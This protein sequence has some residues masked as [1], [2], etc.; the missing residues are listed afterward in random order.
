M[1]IKTTL[2]NIRGEINKHNHLYYVLGRPVVS[3]AEYDELYNSL[4][5]LEKAYPDLVTPTSPTQRVGSDLSGELPT[6]K[7]SIPILSLG[8]AYSPEEIMDFINKPEF[9]GQTF[10]VGP[11]F[12]GLSFSA[13]YEDGLFSRALSRGDGNIGSIITHAVRTI[14]SL[15]LEIPYKKRLEVRG[16][17]YIPKVTFERINSEGKYLSARNLAAGTVKLLDCTEIS[18]RGLEAV[19]YSGFLDE[20]FNKESCLLEFLRGLGFKVI[21]Y[22]LFDDREELV[23]YCIELEETRA[24]F[25]FEM[26][27]AVIKVDNLQKRTEVSTTSKAPRWATAYKYQAQSASTILR[28]VR[29]QVS[30]NGILTPVA[31]FDM[32]SLAGARLTNATLHNAEFAKNFRIGSTVELVRSGEVIPKIVGILVEGDGEKIK[33]PSVCPDCGAPTEIRS[34]A[35]VCLGT[36]CTSQVIE[37]II[38]YAEKDSLDIRGLGDSIVEDLVRAGKV[39]TPVDL[40]YLRKEDLLELPGFA[41]KKAEN[42]LKAINKSKNPPLDKFLHGLGIPYTGVNTS[43]NLARTFK[44]IGGVMDATYDQVISI[45]DIGEITADGIVDFF[46]DNRG[47]VESLLDAGV[48]PQAEETGPIG[49]ALSGKSFVI[50][51]TLS[52]ARSYF[53]KMIAENGGKVVASGVSSKTDYLVVGENVGVSKT[54]KARELGVKVIGETELLEMLG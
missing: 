31:T 42:I 29:W 11:K 20:E 1:F 39:K 3:D 15:P 40:Y 30:R 6:E 41:D 33:P 4:V 35:V 43:R 48:V 23:E 12:D 46:K 53:E 47:F 54:S 10:S 32:I 27:G 2:E 5:V 22:R 19:I 17:I 45:Q 8:N 34:P 36:N 26:D 14:R 51:G 50:T 49:S 52:Q 21:D 9:K 18:R 38:H 25:P 44:T 13:I 24:S 37:R 16:E 28:E 7:H